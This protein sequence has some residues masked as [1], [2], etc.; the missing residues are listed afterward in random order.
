M[1]AVEDIKTEA[2]LDRYV[3]EVE[4]K[5][6]Y[7]RP[8]AF[9][10]GTATWWRPKPVG[11]MSTRKQLDTRF[12]TINFEKNYR[13]WA[14]LWD[15]LYSTGLHAP[16]ERA[17]ELDGQEF[18]EH[19][20]LAFSPFKGQPGHAN[21]EALHGLQGV[22]MGRNANFGWSRARF[23]TL[24]VIRDLADPPTTVSDAYL[25][26]HL[27]SLRHVKPHEVNLDGIFGLLNNV[28]W[29]DR[30]PVDPEELN[31][32]LAQSAMSIDDPR[33]VS[34]HGV[35]KFPRMTD[36]VI[37]SGVRIADANRVRLG[38][39]LAEG[40]TV[41]QEGFVNFNA[42]TLC[43]CMVEGRISAGVTVGEVGGAKTDIGG[44]ASIMGTLSGGGEEVIHIGEGCLLGANSGVG[45]S[46]GPYCKVEAGLYIT[47]KTDVTVI[48]NGRETAYVGLQMS[49][50]SGLTYYRH[51][52]T[53]RVEAKPTKVDGKP[54]TND[55]LHQN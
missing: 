35:D 44:G 1:T 6:G 53:G 46:L 55:M 15:A 25:R 10:L 5:E 3:E 21:I 18:F 27:L 31:A 23:A 20:R 47:P 26:L 4:K 51:G 17:V 9:G 41:M 33:G 42:G 22:G 30:G 19:C 34:V 14:V 29:T 38:A 52:L 45:I 7:F 13:F 37:P 48:M 32:F 11:G 54:F 40:T 50:M 43:A 2:D 39:Y 49:G 8:A 12:V 24:A 28:A 36:Y 16:E